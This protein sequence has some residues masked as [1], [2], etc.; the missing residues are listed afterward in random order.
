MS[1]DYDNPTDFTMTFGN[2]FRLDT[3]EW[4]FGDLYD[5]NSGAVDYVNV[6]ADLMTKPMK[7][8]VIDKVTEYMKNSLNLANQTITTAEN[9]DFTIGTYGIWGKKRNTDDTIDSHQIRIAN[10]II[11][12]TDDNWATVKLALGVINGKSAIIADVIAGKL[13]AGNDLLIT[14]DANNFRVDHDGLN[15]T[16]TDDL[17]TFR[18]HVGKEDGVIIENGNIVLTNATNKI[19]IDPTNGFKIQKK[20]GETWVNILNADAEGNLELTGNVSALSFTSQV[21]NAEGVVQAETILDS[22]KQV[23]RALDGS[24]VMQDVLYFDAYAHTFR[25]NGLV[26]IDTSVIN[27][28]YSKNANVANLTVNGLRSDFEKPY[29]YL[30]N[31]TSDMQ[32]IKIKGNDMRFIH[33]QCLQSSTVQFTTE[34]GQNLY[35]TNDAHTAMTTDSSS[36]LP[37]IIWSYFET[38][39]FSVVWQSDTATPDVFS[40][41]HFKFQSGGEGSFNTT[42]IGYDNQLFF[43]M[44]LTNTVDAYERGFTIEGSQYKIAGQDIE[45]G[46]TAEKVWGKSADGYQGW[47]T[48]PTGSGLPV[49]GTLNQV[50]AKKSATDYDVGWVDQSGGSSSSLLSAK[51][52]SFLSNGFQNILEN[53]T[54]VTYTYVYTGSDL[55]GIDDGH[56][57]IMNVSFNNA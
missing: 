31:D 12:M 47:A 9:Q 32:Y 57:F 43:K 54:V 36:G 46:K 14:N 24:G 21:K 35:W 22:T 48:A 10:N 13:L 17:N 2:R 49:G 41:P 4:T 37:V 6:N 18:F 29:R 8:G 52:V 44:L 1:I 50:L 38:P 53:D 3:A 56:G 19:L 28:L 55:T 51:S 11:A 25:F 26:T 40:H 15:F 45:T 42:E 30:T 27:D 34:D 39:M 16:Q 20:V 7:S 23:M 33:A 5:S